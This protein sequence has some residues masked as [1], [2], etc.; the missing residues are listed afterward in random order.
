MKKALVGLFLLGC[1]AVSTAA[2]ARVIIVGSAGPSSERLRPGMI[3]APGQKL[4]LKQGDRVTILDEKG[5]RILGP[6]QELDSAQATT[7]DLDKFLSQAA[8]HR[9]RIAAVRTI[10]KNAPAPEPEAPAPATTT[11]PDAW[12]L[13]LQA[14]N[15]C[16]R[17]DEPVTF[18]RP[19]AAATA[20]MSLRALET[21]E[22]A[23]VRWPAGE[24]LVDWPDTI[25]PS[26]GARYVVRVGDE[27]EAVIT[28][29][30]VEGTWTNLLDLAHELD[31]K[32]CDA[33]LARLGD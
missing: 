12:L 8:A 9:A 21:G 31:D 19:K 25:T 18:W 14:G 24:Q 28:I 3:V 5:T 2:S 13:A 30:F 32:K 27:P 7:S 6:G 29:R 15:W 26:E 17:K 4:R 33:Q 11:A 22:S 1:A 16:V 23:N 10:V 20:T